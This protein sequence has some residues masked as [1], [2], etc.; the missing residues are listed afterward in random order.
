[1]QT[2]RLPPQEPLR[3]RARRETTT[4]ARTCTAT[5]RKM[6]L[7]N[8]RVRSPPPIL[9][10]VMARDRVGSGLWRIGMIPRLI[11][12][13][14]ASTLAMA[15]EEVAARGGTPMRTFAVVGMTLVFVALL[16]TPR[17]EE[18]TSELQ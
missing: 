2:R 15:F 18:H 16:A 6:W 13:P 10:R 1:M 9:W 8:D 7:S 17:S 4:F 5:R 12:R 11:D 14:G 3:G